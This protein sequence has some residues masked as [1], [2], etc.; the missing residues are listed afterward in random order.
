MQQCPYCDR[1]FRNIQAL[2]AHMRFCKGGF[3]RFNKFNKWF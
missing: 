2:S 1:W 3:N